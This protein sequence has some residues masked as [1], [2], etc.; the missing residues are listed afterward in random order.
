MTEGRRKTK[1]IL[2]VVGAAI[3]FSTGG[4]AIK[5]PAFSAMQVASIR[6]GI[7]AAML[8]LAFRGRTAWSW[9]AAAVGLVYAATLVL[10]VAATKSTT[11]ASAIFLQ[12]TAP[13]YVALLGPVLLRERFR[14]RD[15]GI[16]AAV[17]VGL[18]F[19]LAGGSESTVT[20]P[21]PWT[22]NLLGAIC[23]ITWGLTLLGLRWGARADVT[24]AA[25]AV[26]AGNSF[27]FVV[28]VPT[29]WP[30]PVAPAAEWAT[31]GYLG[32]FQIGVAYILLT[33]AV[34][35]LPALHVSLLLLLEPVLNPVWAWL[36][37]GEQPGTW[38]LVGGA[39]ILTASSMHVIAGSRE[40]NA[41]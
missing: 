11:A 26:V 10:F 3:L 19:C 15:I 6:S 28:G 17:A 22:G 39:I 27:A 12:S 16:L 9:R 13:L 34:G 8:L 18:W 21:D 23:G 2:Q 5:T 33:R 7:A 38:T 36:L 20:A 29:L 1:A 32:I 30:V 35:A 4:A 25:S 31:L 41:V 40:R 24:T 37:R 14:P